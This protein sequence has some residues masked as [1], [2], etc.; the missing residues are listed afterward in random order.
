MS[1]ISNTFANELALLLFNNTD[2]ANIGDAAGL[3]NSATAGSY[4]IALHTADPGDAGNATTN[5]IAYTSYARVALARSSGGWT[6]TARA[7]TN[8]VDIVFP[9]STGAGPDVATH[10]S[11]V[12]E[13]S[14]AS[15][16]LFKGALGSSLSVTLNVAPRIIAGALDLTF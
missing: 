8:A 1:S 2:I 16:I 9:T 15:V 6:V 4:Y 3:Q 12:K 10:W 14:G 11:I 5:E 13:S 7:L